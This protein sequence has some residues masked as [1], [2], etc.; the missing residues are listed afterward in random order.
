VFRASVTIYAQAPEIRNLVSNLSAS[1]DAVIAVRTPCCN[2][3]RHFEFPDVPIQMFDRIFRTYRVGRFAP[4][5]H[6]SA[7]IRSNIEGNKGAVAPTL[8]KSDLFA[9]SV[10][11]LLCIFA[12][13][14]DGLMPMNATEGF[15][16]SH[17][18]SSQYR[19]NSSLE[20]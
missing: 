20:I 18:Q 9:N 7:T 4:Q 17:S 11:I 12:S 6:I 13:A 15:E 3:P 8:S 2:Y 10:I 19:Y 5:L 14:F 1:L 16:S